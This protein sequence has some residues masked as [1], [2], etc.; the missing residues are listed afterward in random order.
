MG[1][2]PPRVL[3]AV[4]ELLTPPA[5]REH[6][7]GDLH[8]RYTG[9][10]QY[11][12]DALRTLPWVIASRVRRTMDH[13]ALLMEAF[14]LYL[15]FLAAAWRLD[16]RLFLYEQD[17]FLRLAIPVV[18]ALLAL[19]LADA[20]AN[21]AK[22]SP[23]KPILDAALAAAFAF[24]PQAALSVFVPQWTAPGWILLTG[25][26]LSVLLVSTL[27]ML[28]PARGHRPLAA[29][30]NAP[31]PERAEASV[32]ATEMPQDEIRRKAQTL[33]ARTRWR[34]LK[35]LAVVLVIALLG[36]SS[37]TAQPAGRRV[38]GGLI[39]AAAVY[40]IYQLHKRGWVRA[41]PP[42][43]ASTAWLDFYRAE[44]ARQRDA[45]RTIWWWYLAPI[46][47]ALV[48]FAAALPL[49]HV[50][51]PGL[52]RN[53]APFVILSVVWCLAMGILTRRI[54]RQLQGEIDAVDALK[55]PR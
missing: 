46:L 2:A 8:E 6:V 24:L 50:E 12:L 41:A 52:W 20:Y 36:W 35:L 9:P 14:A 42:E 18:A 55:R 33:E 7:L 48:V 40:V 10:R 4:V 15:S 54:V 38:A 28:F 19:R 26:G 22:Q 11:I 23:L 45:L 53:I 43:A 5:C 3:E 44:L 39:L 25:G 30:W 17:G 13:Q 21:P 34:N 49:P 31:H 1:P 29:W 51:Q 32:E 27:R 37:L 47:G 16:G